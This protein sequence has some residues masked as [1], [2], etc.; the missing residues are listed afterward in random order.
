[1]GARVDFPNRAIL[2]ER[3]KPEDFEYLVNGLDNAPYHVR[4]ALYRLDKPYHKMDRFE[5]EE[6]ARRARASHDR[7]SIA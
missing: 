1:M 7:E 2:E 3:F 4:K 6:C 5:Q